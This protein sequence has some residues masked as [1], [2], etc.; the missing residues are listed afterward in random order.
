[1]NRYALR[2]WRRPVSRSEAGGVLG[3]LQ[4]VAHLTSKSSCQKKE[5]GKFV[6]KRAAV[7]NKRRHL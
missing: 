6:N 5:E 7:E 3:S 1:L 2:R 4:N